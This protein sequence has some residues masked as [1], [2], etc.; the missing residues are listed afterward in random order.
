MK[1][2]K[3][4]VQEDGFLLLESL[5][6]ILI[7][8]TII[9]ILHPLAIE[10]F[11]KHEQAKSLVEESRSIY[12]KSMEI[13]N[14]SIR[15]ENGSIINQNHKFEINEKGTGVFIYESKFEYE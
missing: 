8:T 4:N 15:N 7:I 12:E 6:T 2:G 5:I 14:Y 3:N 10:W 13:N 9:L 11:S 1:Y